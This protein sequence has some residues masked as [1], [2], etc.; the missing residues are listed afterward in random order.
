MTMIELM[1][2]PNHDISPNVDTIENKGAT[3]APKPVIT[4]KYLLPY[5][6]VSCKNCRC[7]AVI[8]YIAM[9]TVWDNV[10]FCGRATWKLPSR[11]SL[12]YL[13]TVSRATEFCLVVLLI[14]QIPLQTYYHNSAPKRRNL[15]TV[16]PFKTVQ[17]L[18]FVT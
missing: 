5:S 3:V 9:S 6:A 1:R 8:V 15:S 13:E 11:S 12:R 18:Q 10:N 4:E 17:F 16:K 14:S 2:Q 7:R